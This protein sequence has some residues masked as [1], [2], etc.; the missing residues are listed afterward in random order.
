MHDAMKVDDVHIA[1]QELEDGGQVG[2][3]EGFGS[4]GLACRAFTLEWW[5][6][7]RHDG[8]VMIQEG[9]QRR[10]DYA[11]AEAARILFRNDGRG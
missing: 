7:Y 2:R 1:G 11:V 3:G 4:G 9:S 10:R 6:R 5:H 8:V